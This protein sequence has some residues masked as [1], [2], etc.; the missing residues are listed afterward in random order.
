MKENGIYIFKTHNSYKRGG[1]EAKQDET[2]KKI[3]IFPCYRIML[4]VQV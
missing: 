2:R 1:C 3:I 4:S